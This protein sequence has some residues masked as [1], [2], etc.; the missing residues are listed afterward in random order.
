MS[1]ERAVTLDGITLDLSAYADL[2]G[3]DAVRDN[4]ARARHALGAV[5]GWAD[6]KTGALHFGEEVATALADVLADLMHLARY[7]EVDFADVLDRAGRRHLE[8]CE[9]E[10]YS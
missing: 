10:L 4:V 8:E 6:A 1:I 7:A 2:A 5:H 9:A 3:T